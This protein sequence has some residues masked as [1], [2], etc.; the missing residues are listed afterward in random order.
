MIEILQAIALLC[1]IGGIGSSVERSTNEYH[2]REN[3]RHQISELRKEHM[4]CQ[5]YYIK[6]FKKKQGEVGYQEALFTC[7]EERK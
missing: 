2:V 6:C 4:Q 1:H 3:I 5:K 7:A